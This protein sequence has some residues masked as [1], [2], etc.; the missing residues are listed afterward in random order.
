MQYQGLIRGSGWHS[1]RLEVEPPDGGLNL[2]MGGDPAD[3]GQGQIFPRLD[4][5]AGHLA[6]VPSGRIVLFLPGLLGWS[7]L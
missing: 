6:P 4:I 7:F 3:V 2:Q 1:F 5:Q